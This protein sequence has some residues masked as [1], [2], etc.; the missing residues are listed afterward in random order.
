MAALFHSQCLPIYNAAESSN[1]SLPL[2]A[3]LYN[4]A[5]WLTLSQA[6]DRVQ[7]TLSKALRAFDVFELL[8][9]KTDEAD[10]SIEGTNA[11][12]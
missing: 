12:D 6:E 5:H 8:R 3:S 1:N 2:F 10:R 9:I 4:H 11:A 7:E